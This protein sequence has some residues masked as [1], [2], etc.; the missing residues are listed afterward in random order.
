MNKGLIILGL[1]IIALPILITILFHYFP[2][3]DE[4][5]FSGIMFGSIIAVFG[6]LLLFSGIFGDKE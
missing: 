4:N 5:I 3:V 1:H 2:P 6:S